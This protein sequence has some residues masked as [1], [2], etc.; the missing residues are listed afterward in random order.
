MDAGV[1]ADL[2]PSWTS[3]LP[4]SPGIPARLRSVVRYAFAG[5]Y[6]M[7]NALARAMTQ[8]GRRYEAWRG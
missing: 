6:L 4:E 5:S 3:V 1:S 7:R 8:G 2:R